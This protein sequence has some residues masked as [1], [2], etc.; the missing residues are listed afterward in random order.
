M[1]M[2]M[3]R[4]GTMTLLPVGAALRSHQLHTRGGV[5]EV[6]EG[7]TGIVH[8]ETV[9]ETMT[10]TGGTTVARPAMTGFIQAFSNF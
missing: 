2:R 3:V 6:L 4:H 5:V 1:T 7:A 9:T 8:L 10:M